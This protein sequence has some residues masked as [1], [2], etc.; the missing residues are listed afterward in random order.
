MKVYNFF[1]F[2][3]SSIS[4]DFC[5]WRHSF[6]RVIYLLHSVCILLLARPVSEC[7]P[8]SFITLWIFFASALFPGFH[9]FIFNWLNPLFC[10]SSFLRKSKWEIYIII[11]TFDCM[12]SYASFISPRL[13]NLYDHFSSASWIVFVL[14]SWMFF[15]LLLLP[16]FMFLK[17]RVILDCCFIFRNETL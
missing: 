16:S 17:C 10:S 9:D 2:I 1:F 5:P 13:F 15:F 14:S 12:W 11:L 7:Q 3:R 8:W 4:S 6:W